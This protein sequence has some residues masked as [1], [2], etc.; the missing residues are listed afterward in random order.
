[1]QRDYFSRS[2]TDKILD[3]SFRC[4]CRKPLLSLIFFCCC[5]CLF[6][7]YS[8]KNLISIIYCHFHRVHLQKLI[9]DENPKHEK[10]FNTW[11]NYFVRKEFKA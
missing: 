8:N 6:A 2:T 9:L 10:E 4:N 7:I 5:Y 11:E 1:M 3:L